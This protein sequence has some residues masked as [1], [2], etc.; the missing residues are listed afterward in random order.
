[1]AVKSEKYSNLNPNNDRH[2]IFIELVREEIT[3]SYQPISEM[4]DDIE[5]KV[6]ESEKL[7]WSKSTV[8]PLM[9][10]TWKYLRDEEEIEVDK[11]P[12]GGQ[13]SVYVREIK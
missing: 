9:S 5:E 13:E 6:D 8:R 7:D 11:R 2:Q 1:M 10:D 4:K 12:E 3:D